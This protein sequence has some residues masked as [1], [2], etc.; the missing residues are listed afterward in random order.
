M[1]KDKEI[2]VAEA[3]SHDGVQVEA[4]DD[5]MNLQAYLAVVVYKT[6]PKAYPKRRKSL[7]PVLIIAARLSHPN[8]SPT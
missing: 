7:T 4:K 6:S 8:S 3:G 5:R 2:Q 1:E